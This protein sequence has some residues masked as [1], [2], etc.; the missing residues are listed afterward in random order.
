MRDFSTSMFDLAGLA[1]NAGLNE[2]ESEALLAAYFKARPTA[3]SSAP[4]PP[5]NA[6]RC[7]AKPCGAWFPSSISTR[8]ASTT[9]P[10]L[11]RIYRSLT[12]RS[13]NIGQA[14]ENRE[15]LSARA[16]GTASYP[17]PCGEGRSKATG[18]GSFLTIKTLFAARTGSD[19]KAPPCCCAASLP[20]RGRVGGGAFCQ[21]VSGKTAFHRETILS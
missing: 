12:R 10:I 15:S 21:Q 11:P 9:S 20:T 8:R 4:M 1:S 16:E 5:C 17:P 2:D 14:M 3:N 19:Q 18:R 6:L 13:T 7:C